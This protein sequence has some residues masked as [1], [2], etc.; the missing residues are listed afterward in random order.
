MPLPAWDIQGQQAVSA[1]SAFEAVQ[2]CG[3]RADGVASATTPE[4]L[5]E[6]TQPVASEQ[7]EVPIA[8]VYPLERVRD[9][10]IEVEKRHTHGEIALVP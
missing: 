4:I 9:A 2:E 5:A 7:M 8:P 10:Y 6:M 1:A 3:T